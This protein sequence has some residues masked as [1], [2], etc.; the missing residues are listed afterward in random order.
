MSR[1]QELGLRPGPGTWPTREG[2]EVR[3]T[4]PAALMLN[5]AVDLLRHSKED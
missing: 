2:E 1:T 5:S 4:Q 3:C